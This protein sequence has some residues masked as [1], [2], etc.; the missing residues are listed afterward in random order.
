V[1]A[2]Q[3]SAWANVPLDLAELV[4]EANRRRKRYGLD[5]LRSNTKSA[6]LTVVR[7]AIAREARA[8]GYSYPAIGRALNRDHSSIMWAC[9]ALKNKKQ[10]LYEKVAR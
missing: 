10:P 9:G 7:H 2:E 3:L 5:L 4:I 8:R 6:G 1:T